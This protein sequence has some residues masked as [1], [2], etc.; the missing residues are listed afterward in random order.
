MKPREQF[1]WG[2]LLAVLLIGAFRVFQTSPAA[3]NSAPTASPFVV[4][5]TRTS[6]SSFTATA[7]PTPASCLVRPEEFF[8]RAVVGAG[9]FV[10]TPAKLNY[11]GDWSIREDV[12]FGAEHW[13]HP[14]Y[15]GSRGF[16]FRFE[17]TPSND[18]DYLQEIHTTINVYDSPRPAAPSVLSG[19][20]PNDRD[21]TVMLEFTLGFYEA[22][23][24]TKFVSEAEATR[25]L[26]VLVA[27]VVAELQAGECP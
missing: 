16:E 13:D 23:I 19:P 11:T 15:L 17:G 27:K 14:G 10:I 24:K 25:L 26:P 6:E 2:I 12:V 7:S 4:A 3:V 9:D 5:A 8:A 22:N 21:Q 18:S 20:A 1:V